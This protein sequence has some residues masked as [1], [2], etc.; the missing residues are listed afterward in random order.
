VPDHVTVYATTHAFP[1]V[2]VWQRLDPSAA[3]TADPDAGT[4]TF[5]WPRG[6]TARISR[7]PDDEM[8]AHLQAL[9]AYVRRRGAGEGAA[10][11]VLGTRSVFGI[12]VE[13]AV[14]D[15][16]QVMGLVAGLTSVTDGLCLLAGDLVEP[17][18]R[19]LFS[20]GPLVPD[21]ARVARRALVLLAV[22]FRGLLEQDAGKADHAE[23]EAMRGRLAAWL[24]ACSAVD[25]AEP[26]E[27]AFVDTP[28]GAADER[29]V[30]DRVWLGEG[31]QVLL[32]ALGQRELPPHDQQEHPYEVARD[33]GVLGD[34]P[35]FVLAAPTLRDARRI[36][37]MRRRLL[38]IHWRL[39][40]QGVSPGR[41][42]FRELSDTAWFGGFDL[43]GIT[44]S[45]DDLA[46]AGV[47][48]YVAPPPALSRA[49]SI[50]MERHRAVN[51]LIGAHPRYSRVPTPT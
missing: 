13:P 22:A 49:R 44:L 37:Q 33:V 42:D 32:W 4:A 41:V 39:V 47:P 23:A 25:E 40:E 50:A 5:S 24:R 21:A 26:A 1:P 43:A 8:G 10:I 15:G 3:V 7:M 29:E 31:A 45:D 36:D 30:I 14:D 2:E 17:G 16:G 18:G 35:S 6:V 46:L 27:L 34:E 28:I 51:W 19:G 12:V 48:V 11:R 9:Q 20:D 38:G